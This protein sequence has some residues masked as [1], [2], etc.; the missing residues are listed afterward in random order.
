M[1]FRTLMGTTHSQFSLLPVKRKWLLLVVENQLHRFLRNARFCLITRIWRN[2]VSYGLDLGQGSWRDGPVVS[3]ICYS[4]RR[5]RFSS[6]HSHDRS[7]LP[8]IPV[9]AD[10]TP[11]SGLLT[12]STHVVHI[13][14]C[15]EILIHI[16]Q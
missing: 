1:Y 9:P 10:P 16:K 13:H 4:F 6:H 11:S 14:E 3:S 2:G 12:L 8:V 7:K 15:K 5:S